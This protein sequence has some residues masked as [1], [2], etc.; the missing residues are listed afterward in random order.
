[1]QSIR[2]KQQRD[3]ASNS[4]RKIDVTETSLARPKHSGFGQSKK[5][6]LSE[7][8]KTSLLIACLG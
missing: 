2:F 7:L 6:C 5:R 1:M 4:R 3:V 8:R